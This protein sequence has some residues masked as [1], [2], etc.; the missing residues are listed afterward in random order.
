MNVVFNENG[1]REWMASFG[2]Q[3]DT[4]GAARTIT[5]HGEKQQKFPAGIMDGRSMK[6][7][8][9]QR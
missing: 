3:Y 9:R 1:V 2:D 4:M 7:P 6:R 8:N 5:T